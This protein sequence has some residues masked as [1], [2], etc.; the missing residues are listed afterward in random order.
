MNRNDNGGEGGGNLG[1]DK[2]AWYDEQSKFSGKILGLWVI[3][4]FFASTGGSGK[5]KDT[6]IP[7]ENLDFLA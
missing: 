4:K 1:F 3:P 2:K 5:F 6:P 7:T